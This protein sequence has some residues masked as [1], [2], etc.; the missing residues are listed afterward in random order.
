VNLFSLEPAFFSFFDLKE[1]NK[2]P[3][4]PKHTAALLSFR[5]NR[6]KN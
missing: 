5:K 2:N 4:L 6:S 1:K 3:A